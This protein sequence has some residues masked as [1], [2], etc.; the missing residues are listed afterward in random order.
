MKEKRVKI[1]H[2]NKETIE[3]MMAIEAIIE[4]VA[5]DNIEVTAVVDTI[6][7]EDLG[8]V[9]WVEAGDI[10]KIIKE[11][12]KTEIIIIQLVIH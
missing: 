9:A 4:A 11:M 8:E 6:K 7:E 1:D 12:K 3:I 5:V 2:I 10:V